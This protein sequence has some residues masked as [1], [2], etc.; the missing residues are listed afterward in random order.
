M[1]IER[2]IVCSPSIALKLPLVLSLEGGD[3]PVFP[4][5]NL[6]WASPPQLKLSENSYIFWMMKQMRSDEQKTVR[7]YLQLHHASYLFFA[8]G[9]CGTV[10]CNCC[11]WHAYASPLIQSQLWNSNRHV[12][13]SYQRDFM[14]IR[15]IICVSRKNVPIFIITAILLPVW[16]AALEG[17]VQ[18]LNSQASL[19]SLDQIRHITPPERMRNET[20]CFISNR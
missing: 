18:W 19:V 17:R 9:K 3:G 2:H 16:V 10:W 1:R 5:F 8:M 11:S 20:I 6:I 15:L 7:F 4:C 12:S 13:A 14:H